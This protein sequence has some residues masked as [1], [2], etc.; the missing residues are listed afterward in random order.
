MIL[1]LVLCDFFFPFFTQ[2]TLFLRQE[3]HTIYKNCTQFT[4]TPYNLQELHTIYKNS[5]QFACLKI[6]PWDAKPQR[7]RATGVG[8]AD[9]SDYAWFVRDMPAAASAV[10]LGK[11]RLYAGD[12]D[13]NLHAWT[14]EGE[15]LWSTIGEDRIEHMCGASGAKPPFICATAG[16]QIV[17]LDAAS[18][19]TKWF[20]QLVGSSDLVACSEDGE[21]VLATSSVYEIELNDFIESTIWRFNSEGKSLREDTFEERPW[22]LLLNSDGLATMGVGRPRC[23]II[24]QSKSDVKHLEVASEDPV[25]SGSTCG[26]ETVFGHASGLI[27]HLVEGVDTLIK[28]NTGSRDS[29]QALD[30]DGK[31]ILAGSDDNV[32][33]AVSIEGELLWLQPMDG[34]IDGCIFGFDCDSKSSSWV[35]TWDGLRAK[36]TIFSHENGELITTFDNLPRIRAMVNRDS[37]VAIGFD[38]GRVM[39]F[40]HALFTRRLDGTSENFEA[41]NSGEDATTTSDDNATGGSELG[42]MS[43]NQSPPSRT[44]LQTRLRALRE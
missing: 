23:G 20:N 32:V 39:L 15:T 19:E 11:T 35:A 40:E 4:K 1:F 18:G 22:H 24:R 12:W 5:T 27:S 31:T 10:L 29:I 17:C 30:F 21:T 13:G 41:R 9:I 37:R 36:L 43:V 14:E 7:A 38:D 6:S 25:L 3:L 33:R 34:Q 42:D 2:P 28:L 44:S 16:S 26:G 8:V